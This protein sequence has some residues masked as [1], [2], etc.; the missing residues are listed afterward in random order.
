[1]PQYEVNVRAIVVAEAL[2]QDAPCQIQG[3]EIYDFEA[4]ER[5]ADD[6]PKRS[7]FRCDQLVTVEAENEEAA[8]EAAKIDATTIEVDDHLIESVDLW[9]DEGIDVT[10]VQTAPTI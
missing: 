9:V 8:I 7:K 3:W 6:Q 2:S 5:D 4:L 10:L 1:M